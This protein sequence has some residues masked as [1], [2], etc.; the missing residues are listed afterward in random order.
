MFHEGTD[1]DYNV[2]RLHVHCVRKM[3]LTFTR[4]WPRPILLTKN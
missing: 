3:I 1:P 4:A 2:S